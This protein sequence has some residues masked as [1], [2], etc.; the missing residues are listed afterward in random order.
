MNTCHDIIFLSAYI[1]TSGV[2]GR[3]QYFYFVLY[4]HCCKNKLSIYHI[5]GERR[6]ECEG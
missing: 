1:F 5:S 6:D 3:R 2:A 4:S